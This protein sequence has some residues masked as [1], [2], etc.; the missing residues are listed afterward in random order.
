M[1]TTPSRH[2]FKRKIMI[3]GGA[4]FIG[5]ALAEKL[6]EDKNNL[7]VIVDDLST[8]HIQKIPTS[9]DNIRFIKCDVNEYKDIVEVMLSY[10]FHYVF[11]YAAVV[12]VQRTQEHPVNVLKDIRGIENIL[13]ISKNTGV[14]RV[15]Y[16]SSSE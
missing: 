14:K 5:S 7:V 12:G 10:Q 4:G 6:A 16:A 11:H 9:Y 8:G 15:F 13:R 3:T 1:Y 2:S